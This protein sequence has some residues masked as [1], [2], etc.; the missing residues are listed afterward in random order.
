MKKIIF[1]MMVAFITG[2]N[3]F[4]QKTVDFKLQA[5]GTFIN[6]LDGKYNRRF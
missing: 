6:E 2:C 1:L 4:A 3:I 5:D